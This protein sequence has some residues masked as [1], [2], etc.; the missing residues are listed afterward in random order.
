VGKVATGHKGIVEM[1]SIK[2]A[3]GDHATNGMNGMEVV[4][5]EG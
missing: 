3:V 2:G 4:E 5:V 1:G